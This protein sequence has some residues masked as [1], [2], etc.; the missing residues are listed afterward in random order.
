LRNWNQIRP[1]VFDGGYAFDSYIPGGWDS[2][3]TE[4]SGLPAATYVVETAVPAGYKLVKEEDKNVDFGQEYEV[5]RTDPLLNVPV[6]VGDMHTVP[7]QL[8]LFPGVA[9]RYAGEQRPLCDMK[10]VKLED[11]RNAPADF[12]L[13]TEAPV[14]ANVRGFITDD[15]DNE[16]NPQA[17][18]FG[19]KYA[20]PWLPVSF[21]DY[22]GREIARVYSDEF[23][24]YNAMLPPPFTNNIGSPSGVSPQMYE[25]CINSP[26]MTDPASGNLIKDPNFDPQ[27]SNTCL[28]FQFMP[29]ATTYLDTPIIPKA[30]NAGRG[31]FPTDCEFPHHTPVIQKVDSADGGPYVAKPVGGGKEIMIYSA[32]TVEV[33]NPYYE[34]PGS[35]NPKTTFRDHGFGAAQGVVTLDGD[36]LKILEWSADMIRAEVA[37]KHRTGQLMVER[38]DN[39][40]QGLLGIT[41]HV[42]ASGSVHHVANGE[43]IQDAIDNAA[44]GDLILVE[45]GDYREL[46]IVYKDVILQGYGRGAIIN[47]IKSPKEILGQWR[48]KVDKL[49]AQGEFDL[50]PGQQNR[51][52]VFG[53]YRLFANEEGPAVL[54]VNKEN[55]PF[56]N[57][58]IDG[59]T[60]SGADAGGGIFVNGY[61][62]NLTIS[63][64]RII[65][66]QG[67][68]SGAVRLGHPTLTN[69]NGY[70][71]AMNDNV[72]ISHN[73]II[74]N[75]GLDGSGGGVSICTGADDYKIADNFICGNFS[76]GYG[77]G[78]GHRGLSDGGEIVRNWILF[79]KN[80]N[81]G[82]SVNGGGVSLLGAP[83]LPGDVLSPGTGSVTIGSNLIQGNLAGAGRGGG[84]SL[85]QVNGQELGQ[86]KYQVQ[87]F[88]NLV[89]NNIAGA[90]GG[91]VSIADAVDVRIIN[92]TFYSNDSTGTSMESFVAGPLKSTPQISG[93]AYHRP[94]NQVL[95][96]MGETPPQNPVTLDNPVLVNNI[97][98][99][100]RSFYWDSATGPTGGLIPDID[101]GEAPVFSDLGLV[102]YPQGSMLDPR[103]CYLTDATGY[104]AS[105]IGGDPV[106]M[107]DYFNGARDWVIE[108]GGNIVGQP[109][110]DEGGNFIDVHFGPLTL[111]GNYHLAGSSGAINAGTNDY[112][113]V[114]SF[115][116]KDIDSQK[117]PNGNKSDIGA[118]EYYAGANPD[119]GPT[120][121]PAPQ[122]DGGGGF[123]GGG[124]GGGG[125]CFINELV[126]DRY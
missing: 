11:G 54:V 73:Q 12:F 32:G 77:G 56:Q 39:G 92:N 55:T 53:E 23:G 100:N 107:D 125:G 109:A 7:N 82:S 93:L 103:Y 102:N 13:F 112:L 113:S 24:S 66:N 117:R 52:D 89:V 83:P 80:F 120:P 58:R 108:L 64:N 75:G 96:A 36:K 105:N 68:F 65:N 42:G 29:G 123:P 27:Y 43:S 41:V 71:D 26:Y 116:K 114:F 94:Q 18:T 95:A 19:E 69:Q 61:G 78:I 91:G 62:E 47:G 3:G 8:S 81:Q 74:Q 60:I 110:I 79:N 87:L 99:N 70:V 121:D 20:P 38:G 76:A 86:N 2:G 119:P 63:N 104:H 25:V 16:G 33:P 84:I 14:A 1:G 6:C 5:M 85:D 22:T 57:A 35:S 49:F 50:L 115:L 67:N 88:N 45:P 40:R 48:T 51:P 101:G 17:P 106:V 34:G 118:D 59:F 97:F 44:A 30:A 46:L 4:T 28:V 72:F 98:H 9:S 10:Q 31:Q 124:G 90:S 21:H 15:L 126:A 122:P 37:S 111:T